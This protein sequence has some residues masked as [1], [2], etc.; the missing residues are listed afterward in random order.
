MK[1]LL[2]LLT[3]FFFFAGL[4][5]AQDNNPK[6]SGLMFGDYFYNAANHDSSQKDLNGFQF[7]RIYITTD[8][9]ISDNFS[10]RFRL[11]ADQ[12]EITNNGKITTM[13][14]DAWLKWKDIFN[15]SDFIFGISP[16]PAFD[17][18][19]A[20]WG[21]RY[22]EKTI[23]DLSGS[24]SSRDLGID[25]K[26]KFDK[27]GSVKYWLKIGN[28]SGNAPEVNKYKRFY[29]LLEFD[30]TQNF[31]FT[32][33][34]DYASNP[35]KL[36]PYDNE[37]KN[38]SAFVFAGFVNYKQKGSFGLGVEG[39]LKSQ[40]NQTP[41]SGLTSLTNQNG[42]GVSLWAYVNF[43]ETVQIVGRFDTMDPNTDKDKDGKNL[44]LAGLQ[45]NPIKNVCITPNVEIFTYQQES[46]DS[47]VTPRITLN[48]EF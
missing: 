18:S 7:R 25:L 8:Y 16:T 6:F 22:L 41:N 35:K 26:G 10:S 29:G 38:N 9:T 43:T 27:E 2:L 24:V 42:F 15:G 36:D 13:V 28:N 37:M 23:L 48:W 34:G 33:Y 39:F 47:D 11:E 44:I 31:L 19:E 12:G 32:L 14:K 45:F 5:T 20:A 4:S 46:V 1:N 17:V 30:L 21:H 40:Q 3:S